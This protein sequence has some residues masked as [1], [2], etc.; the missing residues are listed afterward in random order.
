MDVKVGDYRVE[1]VLLLTPQWRLYTLSF[2]TTRTLTVPVQFLLGREASDLWLDGVEF[3]EGG[4]D[5]FRRD[6]ENGIV[7]VNGTSIT[8]TVNL[9]G[10]FRKIKSVQDPTVKTGRR[11]SK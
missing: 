11:S 1:D 9:G 8:R 2:T 6:F 5:L 3:Y 4:A 7:L 10:M